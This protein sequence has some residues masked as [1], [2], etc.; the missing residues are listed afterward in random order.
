MRNVESGRD[1]L[2]PEEGKSLRHVF[3][4]VD[5]TVEYE[6]PD[7]DVKKTEA[8]H[9]EA[10]DGA[11][12]ERHLKAAV[13]A[14]ARALRRAT[15]GDCGRLHAHESAEAGEE[16][17]CQKRDRD[18]GVLKLQKGQ[19]GEDHEK[20]REDDPDAR[21]LLAQIRHRAVAHIPGDLLHALVARAGAF[22]QDVAEQSG[23]KRD[24][25]TD[26]SDPPDA[27]DAVDVC[28]DGNRYGSEHNDS[29]RLLI[30]CKKCFI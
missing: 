12:P 16:A 5:E 19:D 21:I 4:R 24:D 17:A 1:K 28:K 18:E 14:F 22:H 15:G 30:E 23:K 8:D 10:H 11:G 25:G 26:G 27:A 6:I 7:G 9:C 20:D 29:L 2:K 13:Q 3:G